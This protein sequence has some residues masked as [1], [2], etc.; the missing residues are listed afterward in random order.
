MAWEQDEQGGTAT[1][2]AP[3]A[4]SLLPQWNVLLHNDD[5]NEMGYVVN[6]IVELT[7]L[8]PPE[9]FKCMIEAHQRGLSLLL[10]SHREHAEF[11]AERFQSK[12][13]TVT[14][15]PDRR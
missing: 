3:R 14:I 12:K 10:Q 13:L 5:N 6:T 9:A 8:R 15:E 2:P 11:V 1:K 7:P 4:P